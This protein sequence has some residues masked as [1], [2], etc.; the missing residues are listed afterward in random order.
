M[1]LAILRDYPQRAVLGLVLMSAQAFFYNAIFFS[2]ALV[3]TR[4][5]G[6]P[7]ASVG[8]YI[9]PFALGNF[10]GPLALGPLFDIVGR[11]PMI[12][13]TYALSGV[14]LAVVGWLFRENL[15]SAAQLTLCWTGI[16][17]FASAAASSAYLTVS[18]SFPLEARALAIALFYALG[19]AARRCGVAMALWHPGRL[20]RARRGLRRL[21]PRRRIDDRCGA[22]RIR[23][24]HQGRAPIVGKRRAPAVGPRGLGVANKGATSAM[25]RA[26]SSLTWACGFSPTFL[27]DSLS[28]ASPDPR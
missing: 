20:G 26:I 22:D 15:L 11:K 14:L 13:A 27:S 25:N 10:V 4:F 3:L 16:F 19:T 7:A 1:A 5:Y 12:G 24:R 28:R 6:V 23:D 21:S 17:F 18:E 2:Y 8:W 9:L